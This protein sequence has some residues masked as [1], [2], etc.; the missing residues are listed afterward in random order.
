MKYFNTTD[1]TG[2][3]ITLD[4]GVA[5]KS[6]PIYYTAGADEYYFVGNENGKVYKIRLSDGA[7]IDRN[8]VASGVPFL[9]IG[10]DIGVRGL[11]FTDTNGDWVPDKL[12]VTTADGALY[13]VDP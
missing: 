1:Y 7:L 4:G 10:K 3:P 2:F 11:S 12:F 5:I 6:Y 9:S 13:V 8:G